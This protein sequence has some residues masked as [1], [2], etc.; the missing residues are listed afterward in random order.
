MITLQIGDQAPDFSLKDKDNKI[1]TLK[2][3]HAEYFVIYFYPQDDT[4]GCTIEAKSF[5]EAIDQF[6]KFNTEIIGI[7]G[8]DETT[9]KLFCTKHHLKVLL[10]SDP[11]FAVAK[12]YSSYGEKEVMG[13]TVEGIFRNTFVL[14]AE[15]KII[16]IYE[17]VKPE[18]HI[19]EVLD[20]IRR[21]KEPQNVQADDTEYDDSQFDE[22]QW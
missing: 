11:D 1:H 6:K 9:K 22:E 16:M 12:K 13:Q 20:F 14:D 19:Q 17:K 2:E 21:Q 18:T 5:T 3:M 10:L 4:P 7:S 15:K 8:G